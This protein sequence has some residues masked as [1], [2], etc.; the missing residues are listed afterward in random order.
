VVGIADG[1]TITVLRDK[2]QVR[3][4]LYG[5]DCPEGGQAFGKKAK[6]FTSEMVFGKVVEVDHIDTDRYGRIVALVRFDGVLLNSALV[7]EGLAWVYN[8]YC[9]LPFCE[10]W[11]V[12]QLKAK[13]AKRGLW[14]DPNPIPPWEYRREKRSE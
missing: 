14:A 3:I 11:F 12:L 7:Q 5:I 10:E 8:Y 9:T 1:D 2:E 4:R 13:D 6:Q